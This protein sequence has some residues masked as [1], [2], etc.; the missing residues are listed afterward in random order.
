MNVKGFV[1]LIRSLQ[2]RFWHIMVSPNACCDVVYGTRCEF[3]SHSPQ[4]YGVF[5]L[6]SNFSASSWRDTSHSCHLGQSTIPLHVNG[7][8]RHKW[9]PLEMVLASARSSIGQETWFSTKEEEFDSPTGH[10]D[11]LKSVISIQV[12]SLSLT[13]QIAHVPFVYKEYPHRGL[14]HNCDERCLIHPPCVEGNLPS[15]YTNSAKVVS[16]CSLVGETPDLG[17]GGGKFNSCHPDCL[18]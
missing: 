12:R 15:Y 14:E 1:G 6:E 16:G 3:E 9:V 2:H 17:S 8:L 4:Y 5:D 13:W 11:E 7:G 18:I 10:S